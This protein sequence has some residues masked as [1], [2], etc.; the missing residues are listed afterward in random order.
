MSMKDHLRAKF[1]PQ[2]LATATK[3]LEVASE[4]ISSGDA[5]VAAI[6]LHSLAGEGSM[7]GFEEIGGLAREAEHL[8]IAWRDGDGRQR[9]GCGRVVR[10]VRKAVAALD[11]PAPEKTADGD[12]DGARAQGNVLVIDDSELTATRIQ[13]GLQARGL[14]VALANS[15]SSALDSAQTA[16][17]DVILTDVNM[18]GIDLAELCRRL[19]QTSPASLIY[20]VSS[21]ESAN[22]AEL[23]GAVGADGAISKQSGLDGVVDGTV[24]AL[25]RRA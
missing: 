11:T 6:E 23:Q 21:M 3:R 18:P 9:V 25:Q 5:S 24:A 20:L 10:K 17:P 8:A 7:L 15:L 12:E 4:A 14:E 22:L 13:D 19:K 16:T 2:F 1:L